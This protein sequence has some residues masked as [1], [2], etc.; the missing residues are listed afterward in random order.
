MK[1]QRPQSA[2]PPRPQR[3]GSVA[4]NASAATQPPTSG[5]PRGG[6]TPR[7]ERPTDEFFL[8]SVGRAIDYGKTPRRQGENGP[9]PQPSARGRPQSA[10]R[11]AAVSAST[12]QPTAT[13]PAGAGSLYSF[14]V[15]E[16]RQHDVRATSRPASATY[17]RPIVMPSSL[18]MG[19]PR[20]QHAPPLST[21]S[22]AATSLGSRPTS[23]K[24]HGPVTAHAE[25]QVPEDVP[26]VASPSPFLTSGSPVM[27]T[28]S[29]SPLPPGEVPLETE[30]ATE[31]E[32]LRME[33][34]AHASQRE[35]RDDP[36][37]HEID[38]SL[39]ASLRLALSHRPKP[40]TTRQ[41]VAPNDELDIEQMQTTE[42]VVSFF[43]S[44]SRSYTPVKFVLM[45]LPTQQPGAH[46]RPYDLVTANRETANRNDY[47]VVTASAVVHMVLNQPTEV[48]LLSD[49][50]RE[51]SLFNVISRV[52]FFRQ[53]LTLKAFRAWHRNIRVKNFCEVRRKLCQHFFISRRTFAG[54]LMELKK[55]SHDLF[56]RPLLSLPNS[57]EG[58]TKE[59]FVHLVSEHRSNVSQFLQS[60]VDAIEGR[61]QDICAEAV[62]NAKIPDLATPEALNQYLMALEEEE[63]RRAGGKRS[64]PKAISMVVM[65]DKKANRMR[66]LKASMDDLTLLPSFIRLVDHMCAEALFRNGLLA[67]EG[68]NRELSRTDDEKLLFFI[69]AVTFQ[70]TEGITFHPGREDF[71]TMYN[72]VAAEL[73]GA[74]ASVS[75]IATSRAFLEHFE[76]TP[77]PSGMGQALQRDDRVIAVRLKTRD[78]LFADFAEAAEATRHYAKNRKWY[79][80]V[81]SEWPAMKLAW[82]ARWQ[83]EQKSASIIDALGQESEPLTAA[84]FT[85]VFRT[86]DEAIRGLAD[87]HPLRRGCLSVTSSGVLDFL[88]SKLTE[89]RVELRQ[90]LT[91]VATLRI[92]RLSQAYAQRMKAIV[93]RPST[94]KK[95]AAFVALLNDVIA[96][97]DRLEEVAEEVAE[98]YDAA[99]SNPGDGMTLELGRRAMVLGGASNQNAIRDRFLAALEAAKDFRNNALKDMARKLEQEVETEKEVVYTTL[100]MV[101][102]PI[103]TNYTA[104]TAE[105]MDY[106]GQLENTLTNCQ[107][108][109]RTYV[110]WQ[111]LF[112]VGNEDLSSVEQLK[113][114]YRGK[115]EL[116]SAIER[117][118]KLRTEYYTS[119]L[120]DV[121]MTLFA[122]EVDELFGQAYAKLHPKH[123]CEA[124]E[125][126]LDGLKEE[127]ALMPTLLQLG[128]KSLK[129]EHWAVI[130]S[131]QQRGYDPTISLDSLR[132]LK[133]FD[134]Q[135]R[136][137]IAEQS[138]IASGEANLIATVDAL[139][140][141]WEAIEFATKPHREQKDS[142]ILDD[143]S[144]IVAQLEEDTLVV[145]TCLASRYVA[146]IRAKVQDWEHK[147]TLLSQVIEEWVYVQGN[148]MYLEFI[149]TSDDIKKQLPAESAAFK[150]TATDFKELIQR[151]RSLKNAVVVA[152]ESNVLDTLTEAHKALDHILRKI[153]EYLETKRA[154]FPRFYF[155][156][157]DELLSI[158]SDSR[159]TR[160]VRP[161]LRKCFD[162]IKD[163]Q[164]NNEAGT[165]IGAMISAEGE[166]VPFTSV[167]SARGPV[168]VWLGQ[169]EKMMV[170]S[171]Q[172]HT[173]TT[174]AGSRNTTRTDWILSVQDSSHEVIGFPAQCIQCVDMVEW[175]RDVELAIDAGPYALERYVQQYRSQILETVA[176]V[177][178]NLTKL[179]RSLVGTLLV[180]DVHNR[181]VVNKIIDAKISSVLDFTWAMQLRYYM[182]KAGLVNIR[183]VDATFNYS[184]EY[185]GSCARLVITPLTD[186]AFLT[187]TSALHMHLGGAP[188]GPAGTGKTESVKDLGKA[189]ARQVV[190]FNCSDGINTAMMSQMFA[191]LAQGGAWAC[192]DEFNRIELEVLS[193]VAQ[194]MLEIT[195]AIARGQ[196]T[197]IFDGH[198]IRLHPNFGVFITMNPG[199]AGRTELPDNLKALFRPVCMMVPDY[200]L[201]AEIMFFSEGFN[202]A[203]SLSTKMVLLYRLSSEQ[204]SKQDHYDFGM[205]AV[206]SI[207]VMAGALKRAEPDADEDMLLIRA[208]RDSNIPKFLRD[209]T[210]LFNALISDLYPQVNIV[211]KVNAMLMVS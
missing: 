103:L 106:L 85:T 181:D 76:Q 83:R 57:R 71:F 92:D 25:P 175:T 167:V 46:Y 109:M 5:V 202:H 52:R 126:L 147:L 95:Y 34:A 184:Y 55:R 74:V 23:A 191:G 115:H 197:M 174:A 112:G 17:S 26:D 91:E 37:P 82:K 210:L 116:W 204:L 157:N 114:A 159:D 195:R 108:K 153:E 154:A 118:N 12:T 127:K 176:V 121:E 110:Q 156:S 50:V 75:R 186:R 72:D 51:A 39:K 31:L 86:V 79:T 88:F 40:S 146:G 207:L 67:L 196:P 58:I 180:V 93:D 136:E 73:T 206:K 81:N 139:R 111:K 190:V 105:V 69:T 53:F 28:T 164:F 145:Q 179:Q 150:A 60:T 16:M 144:D 161:H 185:L 44:H 104:D 128:N 45:S 137:L 169:I 119:P 140:E 203:E 47:Y 49:F 54:P 149:F 64:N 87:M 198:D 173:R 205:R 189:L 143:V 38:A 193:V 160:A 62:T 18:M 148:W 125:R 107:D 48:T 20:N 124:S 61:L 178:T 77:K 1:P 155:L 7:V 171:L 89:L 120:L 24:T 177:R 208:M 199:Y 90:W 4:S 15:T 22:D 187:C 66:S 142:F 68:L 188:Q 13:A 41:P 192:F 9:P 183:H 3:S 19:K 163:L 129:K 96:E 134:I 141:R 122:K 35:R 78:V 113:I 29:Q 8:T 131:N 201:I 65:K 14:D 43:S 42:D 27:M 162:S 59:K 158:L 117:W 123:K 56:M 94:L 36:S 10:T 209:D 102:S 101:D 11:P 63:I 80:Y 2:A 135:Y 132:Q 170:T 133:L 168:E 32:R 165:E 182:D 21:M 33:G 151:A 97:S 98:L 200:R 70:G 194:Q 100:S 211:E 30:V 152:T 130:L 99:E 172:D 138:A 84:G 6:E 166:F